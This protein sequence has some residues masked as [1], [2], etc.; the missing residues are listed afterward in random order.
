[1]NAEKSGGVLGGA[2]SCS[3]VKVAVVKAL[4]RYAVEGGR[5]GDFVVIRYRKDVAEWCSGKECYV[6]TVVKFPTIEMDS[7]NGKIRAEFWLRRDNET[8]FGCWVDV[9]PGTPPGY[10]FNCH[11]QECLKDA[12]EEGLRRLGL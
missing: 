1:M 2:M 8:V 10:Y 7:P 4:M 9:Y 6:A 5:E 11:V 12:I 3:D